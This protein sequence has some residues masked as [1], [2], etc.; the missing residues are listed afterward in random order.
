MNVSCIRFMVSSRGSIARIGRQ[1][2]ASAKA[3]G[4]RRNMK[5]KNEPNRTS[6][7]IPGDNT[8]PV[9]KFSRI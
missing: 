4:T 8:D 3:I 9:T 6:A 7:A 5:K 2:S 1:A